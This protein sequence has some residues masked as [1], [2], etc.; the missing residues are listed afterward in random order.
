MTMG[1]VEDAEHDGPILAPLKDIAQRCVDYKC[2]GQMLE[3][4]A[5]AES[6]ANYWKGK[7]EGMTGR[8][9]SLEAEVQWLREE[10]EYLNRK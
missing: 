6:V 7:C 10:L 8:I 1:Y 3:L 9:E 4:A 5:H 2:E